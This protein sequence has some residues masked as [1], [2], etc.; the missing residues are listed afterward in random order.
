MNTSNKFVKTNPKVQSMEKHKQM[1][2]DLKK[3]WNK[4]FGT[5]PRV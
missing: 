1:E 2:K 4:N 5:K 3:D